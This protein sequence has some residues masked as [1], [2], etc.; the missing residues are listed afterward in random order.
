MAMAR[1]CGLGVVGSV[2]TGWRWTLVRQR[3]QAGVRLVAVAGDQLGGGGLQLAVQGGA[4]LR[5]GRFCPCQVG[6]VRRSGGLV[7][8]RR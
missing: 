7:S 1:G 6:V 2:M 3:G 8:W 5:Q 4:V